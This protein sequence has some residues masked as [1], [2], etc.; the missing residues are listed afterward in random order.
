[1]F[2]NEID[3][4]QQQFKQ[5][6]FCL[7]Q[8]LLAKQHSEQVFI[9]PNNKNKA[10]ML[11]NLK[12]LAEQYL[13]DFL[14]QCSAA[15][16]AFSEN[17]L[18]SLH[19]VPTVNAKHFIELLNFLAKKG[20]PTPQDYQQPFNFWCGQVARQKALSVNG[21]LCDSQIP[22]IAI[23]FDVVKSI[24]EIQGKCDD[25]IVLL[26]SAVSQL[27]ARAARDE[28]NVF[29]N[30]DKD[31]EIAGLTVGNAFWNA[32]LATLQLLYKKGMVKDIYLYTYHHTEQQWNKP[33]SFKLNEWDKLPIRRR[34]MHSLDDKS[35]AATFKKPNMTDEEIK[36]WKKSA[37]RPALTFG[38]MR[39]IAFQWQFKAKERCSID[40]N[41]TVN[42]DLRR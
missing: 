4:R 6:K 26:N 20:I 11:T 22:A 8:K 30:S 9:V 29:I 24:Q 3:T 35:Y 13:D 18:A 7:K 17:D 15:L 41:K 32:E 34:S 5:I 21:T 1:M 31:S 23:L 33:L 36:A 37:A 40:K 28:V 25:Y 39:H 10:E 16:P 2:H 42:P 27:Y 14:T 12:E 19:F 38:S